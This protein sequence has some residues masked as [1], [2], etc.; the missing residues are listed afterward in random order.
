MTSWGGGVI[1]DNVTDKYM[2]FVTDMQYNCGINSW[3]RNCE[4]IYAETVSNNW[5]SEYIKKTTLIIPFSCTPDIIYAPNTDEFVLFYVV[6]TTWDE[7]PP[8]ICQDGHTSSN[9]KRGQNVSE[10]TAFIT[11]KASDLSNG[12]DLNKWSEPI[13]IEVI[14]HGDSN[15]AA[16]INDDSSLVGMIRGRLVTATNWKDNTTYKVYGNILFP[17]LVTSGTEDFYVYKDCNGY[18]HALFHN[19]DPSD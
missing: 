15:F 2:M 18:F 6:N 10:T 1:Y 16:V 17:Y 12:Y 4:I 19:M 3:R 9:C 7:I 14:G 5:N 13:N 8:C 11:I